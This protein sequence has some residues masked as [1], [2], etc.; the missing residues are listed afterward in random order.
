MIGFAPLITVYT[1][2]SC[3]KCHVT[4]K[5]LDKKGLAYQTIDVSQDHDAREYL[6]SLGYQEM[7]V[8]FAGDQR[9]SGFSSTH[10]AAL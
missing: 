5:A 6:I 4:K 8:V 9:W 3:S 7:P 1:Q 10:L 2:P